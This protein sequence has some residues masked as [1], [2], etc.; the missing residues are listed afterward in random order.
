MH[1]H[2]WNAMVSHCLAPAVS[3]HKT[4]R[5]EIGRDISS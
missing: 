4:E 2:Q 3:I 5:E 1:N